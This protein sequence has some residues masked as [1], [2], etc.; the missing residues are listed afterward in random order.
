MR[1][2]PASLLLLL[3]ACAVLSHSRAHAQQS[4][5][6]ADLAPSIF[7]DGRDRWTLFEQRLLNRRLYDQL[8]VPSQSHRLS[9][10]TLPERF[11]MAAD[12]LTGFRLNLTP[13]GELPHFHGYFI[14]DTFLALRAFEALEVNLNLVTFNP[15]ASDGYRFSSDLISGLGLHA[16]GTL[17]QIDGDPLEGEAVLFD[18]DTVTLGAGLWVE[19][20]PLEGNAGGLKWR[21]WSL[22]QVMAGRIMW[23][24]DDLYSLTL[25]ALDGRV[26]LHYM[27]W[28]QSAA[29]ENSQLVGASVDLPFG[30]F[31]VAAEYG[32]KVSNTTSDVDA[33]PQ[34]AMLRLDW[35]QRA[36]AGGRLDLHLG[37][38]FRYYGAGSGPRRTPRET[39][40]GPQ[41]PWREQTYVTHPYEFLSISP[42][43]DQRSYTAMG[44]V[45]WRFARHWSL[46]AQG[47]YWLRLVEQGSDG[48]IRVSSL[49]RGDRFPGVFHDFYYRAGLNWQLWYGLPHLA[50]IHVSNKQVHSLIFDAAFQVQRRFIYDPALI[51]EV[52]VNL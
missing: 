22:T 31:R 49:P 50:R 35:R 16:S 12:G 27:A 26:K 47:E 34:A 32:V 36:L 39:T 4:G 37:Q 7:L 17:A 20:L 6:S 41:L 23:P 51:F 40:T 38:Q 33:F 5:A 25:G 1:R 45:R 14:L 3:S 19:Q 21:H 15:S 44:E 2:L 9:P 10:Q 52:E 30:A 13:G 46:M 24:D 48:P 29:T 18:L 42:D 43:Y 11:T 28:L 8:T